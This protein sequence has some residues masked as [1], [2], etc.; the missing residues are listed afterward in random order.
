MTSFALNTSTSKQNYSFSKGDRFKTT[1]M[2]NGINAY[3]AKD[4]FKKERESGSGK[5][6]GS[7][8]RFGYYNKDK[9]INGKKP[10]PSPANYRVPGQFGSDVKDVN[11]KY[12]P[13]REYS[14]GVSRDNM[15]TIH[16]DD[17]RK[18]AAKRQSPPGP[19]TYEPPKT[20]GRE[21]EQKSFAA[22]L[23]YD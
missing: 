15:N 9:E 8:D 11:V 2:P 22:I 7:I 23:P 19:G 4:F 5:A 1:K 20:F 10:L 16:V 14:F 17:I 3:D 12:G 21:G 6:F 18:K 13:N